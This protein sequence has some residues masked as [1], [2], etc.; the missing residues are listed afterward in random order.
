MS[1]DDVDSIVLK[2][3][4]KLDAAFDIDFYNDTHYEILRTIVENV[5]EPYITRDRNYN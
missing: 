3:S 5:M 1:P 2:L 4:D